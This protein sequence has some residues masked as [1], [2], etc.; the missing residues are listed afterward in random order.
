M[1]GLLI[2]IP[3]PSGFWAPEC[4]LTSPSHS[5]FSPKPAAWVRASPQVAGGGRVHVHVMPR[6]FLSLGLGHT[7]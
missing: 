3:L 2:L 7:G 1:T 4:L 6:D 5:G